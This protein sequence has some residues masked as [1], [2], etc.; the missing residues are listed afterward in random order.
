MSYDE[1]WLERLE[2]AWP[3]VVDTY[4]AIGG[5]VICL[6]RL[7]GYA[8]CLYPGEDIWGC[9]KCWQRPVDDLMPYVQKG[10]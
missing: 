9:L 4:P 7:L 5:P 1:T 8:E 3:E 6:G 2:E 10:E